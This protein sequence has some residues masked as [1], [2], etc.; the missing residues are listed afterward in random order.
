MHDLENNIILIVDDNPTNLAVIS[1]AL[2]DAGLEIAVATSGENALKQ[3]TYDPP[4]LILLDI[5]M[6]GIDGFVTCEKL[7]ENPLTH[8]IPVIFMT[9]L[10]D[11]ADKVKGFNLGAVDYITKPFQQEEVIARVCLHLKMR[12]LTK[13]LEEQNIQLKQFTEE[14]E[15]RVTQRTAELSESLNDLKQ[16][17]IQL[18]QSEKMSA[19]GQ[20]V[21]GIAH[22]INNP[23]SCISGNVDHIEEYFHDLLEHLQLCQQYCEH[24]EIETHAGK[25]DLEFLTEDIPKIIDSAK[26]GAK[27]IRDISNSLRTFSRADTTSKVLADIHEGIDS[28]LM[29]LQHRLKANETRPAIKIIKQ[30][31]NFPLVKCYL[32]QLNQVFMNILANAIDTLDE[33][34][35]GRSFAD[36]ERVPNIINIKTE[37]LDNQSVIIKIKD[38]GKGISSEV[39]SQ[40]FDYLFTTKSVGKGTGL[41]L[42]ISRQIVVE[43]HGGFL[44][45]ESVLGEGTELAI[46]I[47]IT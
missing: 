42:S 10:H 11:T 30:Y 17:Q 18:V 35:Q 32:G 38:N 24:P 36:I 44:S 12:N 5:Q 43:K 37:S 26:L 40:I 1:E 15:Q 8:D 19:L 34:S 6:S 7:K 9:A 3:S 25:I 4:D 29:I 21:A 23:L 47:P 41:G 2:I 16:A 39:K 13:K 20:L 27:R 45:C 33:S 28:T 22:E 46:A 14:L 31:G